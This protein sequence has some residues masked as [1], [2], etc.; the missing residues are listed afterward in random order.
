MILTHSRHNPKIKLLPDELLEISQ[1]ISQEFAPG[2]N[3]N[4]SGPEKPQQLSA[5]EMF[6]ISEEIRLR[7]APNASNNKKEIV[8]LPVDPGHLHAYWNLDDDKPNTLHNP[9]ANEQLTLKIYFETKEQEDKTKSKPWFE[10]AIN[11]TQSQQKIS[12]PSPTQA[13]TYRATIGKQY[14]DNDQVPVVSS[15]ITRLTFGKSQPDQFKEQ[16]KLIESPRQFNTPNVKVAT[17]SN[18][19]AS[20][21]G[22]HL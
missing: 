6:T 12:L 22:A 3:S 2:F 19:R 11:G 4:A 20:G 16:Q 18:N 5:D 10:I 21:Q 17:C 8:L 15:D 13:T 14:P 9:D 1:E 7:F